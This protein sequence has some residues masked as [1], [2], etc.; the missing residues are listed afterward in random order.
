MLQAAVNGWKHPVSMEWI[1]STQLYDLL[2]AANSKNRPKPYPMPWPDKN[3]T[4][5]GSNKDISR[6]NVLNR[7]EQMNPKESNG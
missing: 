4:R 5:L 1:V 7:L 3:K 6:T 2:A